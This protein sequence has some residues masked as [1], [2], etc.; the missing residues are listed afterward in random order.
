MPTP[1]IPFILIGKG[2][3]KFIITDEKKVNFVTARGDNFGKLRVG[4]LVRAT[5]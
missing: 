1:L 4:I 2:Y 3:A 5:H